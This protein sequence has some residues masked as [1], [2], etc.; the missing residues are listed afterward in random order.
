[1]CAR[2]LR[3]PILAEVR[4]S[5][6]LWILDGVS[7]CLSCVVPASRWCWFYHATLVQPGCVV[8]L[9]RGGEETSRCAKLIGPDLSREQLM[10]CLMTPNL[11]S[12]SSC[13]LTLCGASL[14][15]IGQ[16]PI[17]QHQTVKILC[18]QLFLCAS[19]LGYNN[20]SAKTVTS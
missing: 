7:C 4:R 8:T 3:E 12:M 2:T 10:C 20:T 9:P 14:W 19:S 15:C 1:M 17:W 6:A 5:C 11:A 18:V 13:Q 16:F